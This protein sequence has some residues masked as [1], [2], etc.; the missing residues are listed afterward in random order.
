MTWS[1]PIAVDQQ[2]AQAVEEV[3]LKKLQ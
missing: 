3:F 2:I 1:K